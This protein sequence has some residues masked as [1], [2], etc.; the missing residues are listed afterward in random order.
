[1]L[2][3]YK[4]WQ[5][6]RYLRDH[7]VSAADFSQTLGCVPAC[8]SLDG[9]ARDRLRRLV[10]LFLREKV[11]D[12]VGHAGV[13]PQ[14]QLLIAVN[15]C[16]PILNLGIDAY[17]GWVTV[18]VYPDEFLVGYEEEDEAGVVHSGR[19]LRTGEAW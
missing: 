8:H 2:A 19:D 7:L 11:F 15:A 5:R 12:S 10:T 16:L 4:R 9:T 6:S 18:I 13:D 3:W 1:M 17:D 14:D